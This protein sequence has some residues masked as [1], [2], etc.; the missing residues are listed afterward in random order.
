MCGLALLS[1]IQTEI[2]IKLWR[3]SLQFHK[4]LFAPLIL[5]WLTR[6]HL[7]INISVNKKGI[8]IDK[9]FTWNS[10]HVIRIF[11]N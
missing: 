3:L 7:S 2:P 4:F 11:I 6:Y 8:F 5:K 1:A 10:D 9:E